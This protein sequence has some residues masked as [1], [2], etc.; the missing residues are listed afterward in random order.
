[1]SIYDIEVRL[2]D[3]TKYSL[4]RY[5]E[6]VML[7]VNTATKCGFSPQ[8]DELEAL[9]KKYKKDGFV[10]LGFPSNQFH[11]EVA[12]AEEAAA[13]CRL[14]YGVTFPMHEVVNVNGK[15]AHP[16]FQ[17]VTSHS[18]GFLGKSVKWNFTKFL[19]NQNG[20]IVQR[21]GSKDKPYSFEREILKYL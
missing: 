19:V 18:K 6:K 21:F 9:Y 2:D 3:G 14:R 7:I 11:Q 15:D 10:V 20:E 13:N 8:F 5:K 4:D 17:Y 16:V 12:S 1:M